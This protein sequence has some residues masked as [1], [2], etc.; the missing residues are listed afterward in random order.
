M[1]L[2]PDAQR[3]AQAELDVVIGSDSLPTLEDRSRL[4]YVNALV[5][6]VFRWQPVTPLGSSLPLRMDGSVDINY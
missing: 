5:K 3:K 6:E 2:H 1:T 4:P